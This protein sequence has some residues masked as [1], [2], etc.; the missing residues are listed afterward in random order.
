[1]LFIYINI[2]TQILFKEIITSGL[3]NQLP[4][5]SSLQMV[6]LVMCFRKLT[7]FKFEFFVS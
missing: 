3:H 2:I 5:L 4:V 7:E 6:K 1:M